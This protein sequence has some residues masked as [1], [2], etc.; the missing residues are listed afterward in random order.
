MVAAKRKAAPSKTARGKA[1]A[2]RGRRGADAATIAPEAQPTFGPPSKR[3]DYIP[4]E[5]I[6]RV[7]PAAVRPH[8]EDGRAGLTVAAARALPDAVFEPLDYMRRNAGL[9]D[10]E[11]LS[12]PSGEAGARIAQV[13]GSASRARV[14][15]AASVLSADDDE[16]AGLA[17]ARVSSRATPA[18]LKRVA[19]ASS[20]DFIEF[21]P[22]RWL[23]AAGADPM[24]N[25]QWGLRAIRWFE[26]AKP[27]ASGVRV[28]LMDTGVDARHPDLKNV[29]I[30]YDHAGTRAEDIIGHGTHVAGIMAAQ[31]NNAVGIAGVAQCPL[32]VWKIFP[33]QPDQGNFYVDGRRFQRAL[34]AAASAGITALNL[35]IGGPASSRT[36]QILF[37]RLAAHGVTVV[38]AMGNEYEEGNAISYPAAYDD[39]AAVG[40]LAED[41]HR[42]SFSNTG[43]HIDLVA[44]GSNILSTV[45]TRRSAYRNETNYA[46]WS[47]TS[48]ATPHVTATAAMVALEHPSWGP[49]EVVK[50]LRKKSGRLS[51][52]GRRSWTNEYGAGLLDLKGALS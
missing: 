12:P 22:A 15:V 45:P 48:M 37:S 38:A 25:A 5:V 28:G 33:D 32:T 43:R 13:R 47:G 30:D 49:A 21:M 46:V 51:A 11:P 4:G 16:L 39:V 34:V 3:L 20:I 50:H 36:E 44:P 14:A 52:M 27:D 29:D 8:L 6:I 40:S 9:T 31:V 24:Q 17:T 41:R 35:S 18:L 1:T 10:I 42:S 26:A 23:L 7:K 2:A 19:E